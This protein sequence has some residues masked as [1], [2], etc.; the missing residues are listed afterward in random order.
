MLRFNLNALNMAAIDKYISIHPMLR[1]NFLKF[2]CNKLGF[3]SFQ[4]ILCY[5]STSC[6]Q[7]IGHEFIKFQYILC[8]GSTNANTTRATA[9]NKISIHPM[10]RFN[11]I[12]SHQLQ[13]KKGFQYIL[14]YGSTAVSI[15]SRSINPT[16]QYILCYGSTAFRAR[17]RVRGMEFQYILCYGSTIC[18]CQK[19]VRNRI[20]IHPMLRFNLSN[21]LRILILLHFNTSYVTVQQVQV[22]YN[23]GIIQNFNTSYVTVQHYSAC[24]LRKIIYYFNTSYVTVQPLLCGARS[25]I[26]SISIHPMLRF[27]P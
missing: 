14:C 11:V 15:C 13:C 19:H 20:S 21:V 12:I 24:M 9:T 7:K 26:S 22:W 2:V 23:C 16:F 4:Y 25:V 6:I 8:Y 27:N 1:F 17:R 5:G 18:P 3:F 10:L